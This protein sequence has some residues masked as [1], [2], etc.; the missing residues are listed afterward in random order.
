[1]EV[2]TFVLLCIV[3][4]IALI[5]ICLINGCIMAIVSAP[6]LW[7]F[8]NFAKIE[9]ATFRKSYIAELF[10]NSF[11]FMAFYIWDEFDFTLVLG[12]FI[13][14]FA[15]FITIVIINYIF[16]TTWRKALITVAYKVAALL[17]LLGFILIILSYQ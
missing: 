17:L 14:V 4:L 15:V 1:M 3:G 16:K 12:F 8:T 5:P 7:I 10:S 11:Y 13:V 2:V 6:V 9:Y